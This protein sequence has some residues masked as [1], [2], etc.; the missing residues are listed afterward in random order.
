MR[1]KNRF[2][3]ILFVI[4]ISLLTLGITGCKATQKQEDLI[5]SGQSL[6]NTDIVKGFLDAINSGEASKVE[7]TLSTDFV[8]V[9]K[10]VDGTEE[11]M[12]NSEDIKAYIQDL[13]TYSTTFT[14]S[15]I[16]S[17]KD[18]TVVVE[19]IVK[20]DVTEMKNLKEGIRFT[21]KYI[22]T[23]G[24]IDSMVYSENE[25]DVALLD[26][27]LEGV[28][29]MKLSEK[30]GIFTVEESIAGYAAQKAGIKQGDILETVDGM[31]VSKVKHGLDEVVNRIRGS[32]GTKVTLTIR[33]DGVINTY[34]LERNK[35]VQE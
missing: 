10:A 1:I 9:Y 8:F 2:V 29:G 23:E 26:L 12:V 31:E 20:D 5:A 19:G 32:I 13:I 34:V 25:E 18:G 11:E 16:S 14:I 21:G 33:R 28:V 30:D 17:Q 3:L 4:L 7:E 15:S 6:T 27:Y 35:G 24:K 22:L